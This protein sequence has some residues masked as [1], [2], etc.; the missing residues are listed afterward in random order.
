MAKFYGEVGYVMS[1]E[2]RPG[3]YVEEPTEHLYVGDFI[4]VNSRWETNSNLNDDISLNNRLSIVADAFAYE[5]FSQ[6]R[7]VVI[8]GVA[9]KV[10]QIE[11]SAPRLILSIG[12]VYN[13]ERPTPAP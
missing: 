10:N 5:H 12:G 13:G 6:L 1:V 2:K 7:Y 11:V 9:W 8:N 4:R 3:V